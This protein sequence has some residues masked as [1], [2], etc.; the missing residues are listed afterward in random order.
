MMNYDS[1]NN[2][3]LIEP[4]DNAVGEIFLYDGSF[5]LALTKETWENKKLQK[6]IK[7]MITKAVNK[8][9]DKREEK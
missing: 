7:L 9:A 3:L 2:R 1:K 4:Y 5:R 8:K 6:Q